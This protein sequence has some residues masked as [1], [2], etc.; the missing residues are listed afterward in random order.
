MT[1]VLALLLAA[2]QKPELIVQRGHA[3]T[4]W[5][6][7]F[8]GDGR[9]LISSGSDNAVRVWD[10]SSGLEIGALETKDA[11]YTNLGVSADDKYVLAGQMYK[12]GRIWTLADGKLHCDFS[13]ETDAR[14][15]ATKDNKLLAVPKNGGPVSLIDPAACTGHIL[16]VPPKAPEGFSLQNALL[17]NDGRWI[18]NL[19]GWN[20]QTG[21][22]PPTMFKLLDAQGQP[23]P[24]PPTIPVAVNTHFAV[25]PNGQQAVIEI[26]N[27]EKNDQVHLE[28]IDLTTSKTLKVLTQPS[29]D[30]TGAMVFLK[31][32]RHLITVDWMAGKLHRWDLEKG[33]VEWTVPA[34]KAI[35]QMTLSPDERYV[36][37][38]QSDG[39]VYVWDTETGELVRDFGTA[40]KF[41]RDVALTDNDARMVAITREGLAIWD[42]GDA[43]MDHVIALK[44]NGWFAIAAQRK[45]SLVVAQATEDKKLHVYDARTGLLVRD[46][47]LP[48]GERVKGLQF[49]PDEKTLWVCLY[50]GYPEKL[51]QLDFA[52]GKVVRS[53][54]ANWYLFR[55]GPT[56]LPFNADN[57]QFALRTSQ[58]SPWSFYDAATGAKL[59]EAPNDDAQNMPP[60]FSP[61][62]SRLPGQ[63]AFYDMKADGIRLRDVATLRQ[64]SFIPTSAK[65]TAAVAVTLDGRRLV[66]GQTDGLIRVF[67]TKDNQLLATFA[68]VNGK[69]PVVYTSDGYYKAGK[70]AHGVAFRIG[71]KPFP[72]ESFDLKLNRPDLVLARLGL[73]PK[74]RIEVYEKA[75]Q[76]RLSRMGYTEEMLGDN[77][78]LPTVAIGNPPPPVTKEKQLTLSVK[79][80]DP[81]FELDRLY[82]T[83]NGVPLN[84]AAGIDLRKES[85]ELSRKVAVELTP[86]V[87]H[88][89]VSV[90]NARGIESARESVRVRYTGPAPQP[91]RWVVAIGVS[92]YKDAARN[93][94]YAAK[95]A[96]DL[97]A[98]LG[99]DGPGFAGSQQIVLVDS[100]A[101]KASILAIRDQLAKSKPEDQVVVFF[102]GHGVL[103][104]K[105]DYYLG[106]YD[107]DFEQPAA[108]GLSYDQLESL[109][110][111]IPARQR[112][113]LLDACHS[114][115]VDKETTKLVASVSTSEGI[116][117]NRGF[118]KTAI[119][120]SGAGL[121]NSFELMRALFADLRRGS[122]AVVISSASGTQF[123]L[124]SPQWK[125]GVFTYAVLDG[126]KN[127]RIAPSASGKVTVSGLRD[128]VIAKVPALTN[129]QQTP[130]AR[131]E[132]LD[133]DF[134]IQ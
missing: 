20:N 50:G 106:T 2:S 110:D 112:I 48:E 80:S 131:Q 39:G 60:G 98:A 122:G 115:E 113:L 104:D 92:K 127:K 132:Q 107:M 22:K 86:G 126:L 93:L 51:L 4:V 34:F 108:S 105:L 57:S 9:Q 117:K 94:D 91:K 1:I 28:L 54:D 134:A 70:V 133:D 65:L 109:L 10:I 95:D 81:Q 96:R 33:V 61:I 55:D 66:V 129:G 16:F 41:I 90:L 18:A 120:T 3:D 43:S 19:T 73:V 35:W 69:D 58:T 128:Y 63:P 100:Q 26:V 32:N 40:V 24:S 89:E 101:T 5:T 59:R 88:L 111:G 121:A 78:V 36:A 8:T 71:R 87:N 62:S 30:Q 6:V 102:A 25:S 46:L 83:V 12:G 77:F 23:L 74:A 75:R 14:V 27:G 85:K 114:G 82:V 17:L 125:N 130:T 79:A 42:L 56:V 21:V 37:A 123:A 84:G 124:E 53:W 67:D 38:A 97:A 119:S 11:Y 15:I 47:D 116:V 76:K 31:D 29:R 118:K 103:D 52:T 49:S 13:I 44:N 68:A 72:F 7:K 64:L 45:G 99:G